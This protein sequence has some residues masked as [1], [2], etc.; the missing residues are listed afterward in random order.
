MGNDANTAPGQI[1]YDGDLDGGRG[2]EDR[3]LDVFDE[4]LD[5]LSR[6]VEQACERERGWL[7]RL[8]TGVVAMLGFFDDE[9][10]WARVL[11]VD[12]LASSTIALECRQRLHGVLAALLDAGRAGGGGHGVDDGQ[13][14]TD[15][16][17]AGIAAA[18]S[19]PSP[20]LT[21]E[22]V[23][24]GVFSV[25]RTSLL[26]TDGGK[27]VELAPSLMAFI[28]APYLGQGAARLELEGRSAKR[29]ETRSCEADAT[30]ITDLSRA[31]AIARTAELPIR[32]THRT[33]LVLRAITRAP[34]S[35]NREIAQA[36]GITDEGQASKLLARLEGRGVIENVGIGAARGEP[37]AW[38]LTP[39][40][41]RA[42][43][44]ITQ[45]FASGA[46]RPRGSRPE[47]VT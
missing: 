7:E 38:L 37:N 28:V 4:G 27:L 25:I 45:S 5:R 15:D 29:G 40:G 47:H 36:A 22:L 33:T 11:V 46:P 35:N 32:V 2:A 26:E 14:I 20:V 10:A 16:R 21:A 31:A 19:T 30:Q 12:A 34:Y 1:S 9:P 43:E 17:V 42:I 41:R 23:V 6:G 8:R 24:G 3:Y 44:W 18:A 13:P 39:S